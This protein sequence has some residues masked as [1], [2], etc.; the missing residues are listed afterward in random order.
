MRF[1]PGLA[2]ANESL[3]VRQSRTSPPVSRA[4][5]SHIARI[6]RHAAADP[7]HERYTGRARRGAPGRFG[8]PCSRRCASPKSRARQAMAVASPFKAS[9]QTSFSSPVPGN[10]DIRNLASAW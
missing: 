10:R 7:M 1:A 9:V 6:R 4:A 3:A 2:N 8:P 5:A